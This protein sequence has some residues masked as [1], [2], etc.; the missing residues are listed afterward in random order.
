M[1][2]LIPSLVRRVCPV[3]SPAVKEMRTEQR[4]SPCFK[5]DSSHGIP[6]ANCDC[7][8]REGAQAI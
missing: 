3:G 2:W 6:I 7:T 8:N 1:S 5:G 4:L